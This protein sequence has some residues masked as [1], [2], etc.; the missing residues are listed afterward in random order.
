MTELH[1]PRLL[2]G[3][4]L[5]GNPNG[6]RSGDGLGAGSVGSMFGDG[7]GDGF[8]GVPT[9]GGYGHGHGVRNGDGRG[10]PR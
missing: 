8:D 5:G 3:E 7:Y 4:V 1:W 10:G 9:G 2:P 6:G